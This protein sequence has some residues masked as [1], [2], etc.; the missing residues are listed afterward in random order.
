[1]KTDIE[2]KEV[3]KQIVDGFEQIK[4]LANN[5]TSFLLGEE[6]S[7]IYTSILTMATTLDW[8]LDDSNT[9]FDD[10]TEER[11][12]KLENEFSL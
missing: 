12:N 6:F 11:R 4:K 7:S 3:R 2:I 9:S 5:N 1:M 10:F 8:V